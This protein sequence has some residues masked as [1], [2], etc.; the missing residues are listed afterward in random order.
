MREAVTGSDIRSVSSYFSELER[1][2]DVLTRKYSSQSRFSKVQVLL[3]SQGMVAKSLR[4]VHKK[5]IKRLR[6]RASPANPW[7]S[8]FTM[9]MPLEVFECISTNILKQTNFGHTCRESNTEII[10]EINDLRKAKYLFKR[11]DL[12]GFAVKE[13]EILKKSLN[14][15][16]NETEE[17]CE[18]VVSNE[19]LFLLKFH[20][21]N[22]VLTVK[23]HYG[24][25]NANGVAQH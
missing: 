20:K 8:E 16:E 17:R 21:S 24:S 7:R 25:W 1:A 14:S 11:M 2:T 22:E 3:P 9:D 4:K 15:V 19:K 5:V 13:E 23:F 10:F 18:V 12:D 6:Q